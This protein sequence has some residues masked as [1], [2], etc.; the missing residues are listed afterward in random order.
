VTL[1]GKV[2]VDQAIVA[3]A[4]VEQGSFF[5]RIWDMIKLFFIGLFS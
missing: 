3:L 5:K 1:D 2:V 4:D